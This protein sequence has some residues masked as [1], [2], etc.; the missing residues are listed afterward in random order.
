MPELRE[1]AQEAAHEKRRAPRGLGDDGRKL[2]QAIT[3]S[4]ELT[5]S[6][7]VLLEESA[8]CRDR[9]KQLRAVVDAEG[10]TVQSPQGVKAHPALVEERSQRKMLG[11]LLA[12]MR[13]PDLEDEQGS[14][15]RG[16]YRPRVA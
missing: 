11:Q 2:W 14:N 9:I 7:A 13:L 6:E 1:A 12:S 4:F 5:E 8:R 16:F 10:V 3:K 15:S